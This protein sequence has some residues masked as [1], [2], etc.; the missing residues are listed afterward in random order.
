M[1]RS[2]EYITCLLLLPL[3]AILYR[4]AQRRRVL[5]LSKFNRRDQ[6]AAPSYL[7]LTSA[8]LLFA[9]GLSRPY[10]GK[11]EFPIGKPR[12]GAMLVVD[13]SQSMLVQDVSPNRLRLTKRKLQDLVNAVKEDV[14]G[15]RIGI[16]LFAGAS[17]VYCPPT[18]DY[19]LLEVFIR[20]IQPA[21]ISNPGSAL[22]AALLQASRSLSQSKF[23]SKSVVLYSDGEDYY[24][25]IDK[26][27]KALNAESVPILA[28]GVGTE[29]GAPVPL[30]RSRTQFYKD[31]R[32]NTVMSKLSSDS[33]SSL[34]KETGGIYTP[35]SIGD[36]DTTIVS[37]FLKEHHKKQLTIEV[38][39]ED[40]EKT[41]LTIYHEL[42][43]WAALAL[44]VVFFLTTY[45]RDRYASL[46]LLLLLVY[47]PRSILAE[48]DPPTIPSSVEAYARGDYDVAKEGFLKAY[49]SDKKQFQDVMRLAATEYRLGQYQEAAKHYEEA[50]SLA[51]NGRELY[52]SLYD[53]G[54]ALLKNQQFDPAIAQYKK[55][56]EVKARDPKAAFNMELAEKLKKQKPP[57]QEQQ[58]QQ[59]QEKDQKNKDNDQERQDQQQQRQS[60]SQ[61]KQDQEQNQQDSQEQ[62][63]QQND[64][65]EQS[66]QNKEN[67]SQQN[68]SKQE[69]QSDQQQANERDQNHQEGQD[70]K[71][72]DPSSGDEQKDEQEKQESS[73]EDQE[74]QNQGGQGNADGEQGG[75]KKEIDSTPA[76]AW[77][78][79][80]PDSPLIIRSH[81]GKGSSN[82]GQLW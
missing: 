35:V 76:R 43:S 7:L 47:Y 66:D 77:L 75:D 53:H 31:Q 79:S 59:E 44:L 56:L 78:D 60:D 38:P 61:E 11:E 19:T 69:Q 13:I 5:R 8:L 52:Q 17:Y 57:Q 10:S 63:Q 74:D 55:A 16:T 26:A 30:P 49:Q 54:N 64:Q 73:H 33:L 29:A 45:S 1:F 28:V 12:A 68:D 70:D 50:Q 51:R 42:G 58:E 25:N 40:A 72:K 36:Q 27:I 39:G 32:G 34:A 46:W 9:L 6:S 65:G 22:E 62:D 23:S 82:G 21:L 14:P 15:L 3:I 48:D 24:M 18:E 4:F 67:D 80:L 20:S 81:R 41:H 71:N 37:N 2:P